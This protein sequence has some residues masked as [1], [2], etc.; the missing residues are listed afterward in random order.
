MARYTATE[1]LD[2]LDDDDGDDDGLDEP[3]CDG[4][5]EEMGYPSDDELQ[6][7][8]GS[9]LDDASNLDEQ[10][11]LDYNE[12]VQGG[13]EFQGDLCNQEESDKEMSSNSSDNEEE[14]DQEMSGGSSTSSDLMYVYVGMH[15]T[16]LH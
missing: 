15:E 4:S 9:D 3:M 14:S 8:R 13:G 12:M 11:E 10:M 5:D 2:L 6:M 16:P 1:V 7:G